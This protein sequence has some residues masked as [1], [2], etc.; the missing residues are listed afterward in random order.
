M[1]D[2]VLKTVYFIYSQHRLLLQEALQ[3]LSEAVG[4]D[5]VGALDLVRLHAREVD[6][7]R[8]I[9]ECQTLS[10]LAESG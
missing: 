3:R 4:T 5:E 2:K 8:V 1:A 6:A 9:S 10:F 7:A